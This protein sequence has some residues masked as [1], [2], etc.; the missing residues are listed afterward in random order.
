VLWHLA[1]RYRGKTSIWT[2]PTLVASDHLTLQRWL[3][4]VNLS[5]V[6]ISFDR[7]DRSYYLVRLAHGP[8]I[9]T[10]S[11]TL[12]RSQGM[13]KSTDLFVAPLSL[14][15][16]SGNISDVI[17]TQQCQT[18]YLEVRR[19]NRCLLC[20]RD[21]SV[22]GFVNSWFSMTCWISRYCTISI[23]LSVMHHSRFWLTTALISSWFQQFLEICCKF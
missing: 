17:I 20:L 10:Y 1:K 5:I 18:R 8:W 19:F 2:W 12:I 13:A 6:L 16:S 21:Y 11:W 14:T 3:V 4:I 9:H 22:W 7:D 23:N 15:E